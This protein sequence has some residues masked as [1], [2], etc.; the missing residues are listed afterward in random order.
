MECPNCGTTVTLDHAAF[1]PRCGTKLVTSVAESGV[2]GEALRRYLSDR[3]LG[4]VFALEPGRD[5]FTLL[6]RV[7]LSG[8][9]PAALYEITYRQ[10]AVLTCTGRL[11]GSLPIDRGSEAEGLRKALGTAANGKPLR[12]VTVFVDT[13]DELAIRMGGIGTADNAGRMCEHFVKTMNEFF[14]NEFSDARREFGSA[15]DRL[16]KAHGIREFSGIKATL[17]KQG[18]VLDKVQIGPADQP[19][20]TTS[21]DLG[22][23]DKHLIGR[24]ATCTITMASNEEDTV[25]IAIKVVEL[26]IAR[27]QDVLVAINTANREAR[28]MGYCLNRDGMLVAKATVP[29]LPDRTADIVYDTLCHMTSS[30]SRQ[31]PQ[32]L[33][34]VDWWAGSGSIR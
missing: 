9:L 3:K 7:A 6:L 33:E 16:A 17:A 10:D 23:I 12:P 4:D 31:L 8:G 19:L 30:L 20:L 2:D 22:D 21:I 18:L 14:E 1:C 29:L 34:S 26:P 25:A 28:E 11:A 5:S 24:K 27:I 13:N 15:Q 32:V